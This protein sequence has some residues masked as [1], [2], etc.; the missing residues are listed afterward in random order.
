M[1]TTDKWICPCKKDTLSGILMD[2]HGTKSISLCEKCH[3]CKIHGDSF[4]TPLRVPPHGRSV[5]LYCMRNGC[6]RTNKAK[7]L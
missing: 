7:S 3:Q 5:T 2:Y 4:I 1:W 6:H